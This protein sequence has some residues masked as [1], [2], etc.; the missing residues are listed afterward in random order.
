MQT[1]EGVGQLPAAKNIYVRNLIDPK[2]LVHGGTG[3]CFVRRD[4][5][6]WEHDGYHVSGNGNG[7]TEHRP[8]HI[9]VERAKK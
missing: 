2:V 9:I 7:G 5:K 6:A 8:A 1:V 4:G 3:E